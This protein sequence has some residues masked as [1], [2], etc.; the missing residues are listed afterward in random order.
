MPSQHSTSQKRHWLDTRNRPFHHPPPPFYQTTPFANLLT[1]SPS[2]LHWLNTSWWCFGQNV[3]L[4][5]L[6]ILSFF[7]PTPFLPLI[8]GLV[9]FCALHSFCPYLSFMGDGMVLL[10]L[11]HFSLLGPV[12]YYFLLARPLGLI[13]FSFLF[14]F[15]FFFFSLGLFSF[16]FLPLLTNILLYSFFTFY[17]AS[18]LFGLFFFLKKKNRHQQTLNNRPSS[19]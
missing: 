14:F 9:S 12:Y 5:L 15:F 11:S 2:P 4:P 10:G 6:P 18:P 19:Q 3:V 1:M 17:W 13:S 16:L 8:Y 7:F